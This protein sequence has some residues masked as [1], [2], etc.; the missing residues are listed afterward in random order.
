M[1]KE[2]VKAVVVEMEVPPVLTN[3]ALAEAVRDCQAH[4][5]KLYRNYGGN[6]LE[7]HSLQNGDGQFVRIGQKQCSFR[8]RTG[9]LVRLVRTD[10]KDNPAILDQMFDGEKKEDDRLIG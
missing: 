7:V 9:L 2:E 5:S 1:E 6:G 10:E 8:M 4:W 3:R